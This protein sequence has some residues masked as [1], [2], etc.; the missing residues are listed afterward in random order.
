MQIAQCRYYDIAL[1]FSTDSLRL[2][3]RIAVLQDGIAAIPP[4]LSHYVAALL[5]GYQNCRG[6]FA[7]GIF[8]G[9]RESPAQVNGRMDE[10]IEGKYFDG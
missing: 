2:A 8:C 10:F 5:S 3:S 4:A 7:F 1:P 9:R 6:R